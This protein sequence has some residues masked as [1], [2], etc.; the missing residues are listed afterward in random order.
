MSWASTDSSNHVDRI[1]QPTDI[2]RRP[3]AG[4]ADAGRFPWDH[5]EREELL[6]G[7]D[8]LPMIA[9]VVE[10]SEREPW[11]MLEIE[12]PDLSLIEETA[13]AAYSTSPVSSG[14]P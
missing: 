11:T 8:M 10:I 6:D 7:D 14:S 4:A 3:R 1:A 5:I 13:T 9:E 2:F 12:K